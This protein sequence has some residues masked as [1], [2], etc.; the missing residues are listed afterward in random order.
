M[1]ILLI[2]F[3]SFILQ[4]N[5]TLSEL[6]SAPP[7]QYTPNSSTSS[8]SVVSAGGATGPENPVD[9]SNS[10]PPVPTPHDQRVNGGLLHESSKSQFL[11]MNN[12]DYKI[13]HRLSNLSYFSNSQFNHPSLV[14]FCPNNEI[15]NLILMKTFY[16]SYFGKN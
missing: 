13:C 12:L 9:L 4:D 16:F 11:P 14:Q 10:R 6:N 1:Y 2:D 7:Q 3:F 8:S 5:H 15:F